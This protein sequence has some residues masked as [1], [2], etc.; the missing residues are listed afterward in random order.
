MFQAYAT[1]IIRK[2]VGHS[3]LRAMIFRTSG[4]GESSIQELVG[5]DLDTI[6]AVE[7]G[8]CAASGCGRP[9][10]HRDRERS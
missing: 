6:P 3:D 2:I 7:V 4:I 1:P 10:A 8:Y 5:A 9:Q